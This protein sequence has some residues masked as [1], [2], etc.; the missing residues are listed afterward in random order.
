MC[1]AAL[2]NDECAKAV[3]EVYR[4][5]R[6]ESRLMICRCVVHR[7]VFAVKDKDMLKPVDDDVVADVKK[8][9]AKKIG[10][11]EISLQGHGQL[12]QNIPGIIR[13]VVREF[14]GQEYLVKNDAETKALMPFAETPSHGSDGVRGVRLAEALKDAATEKENDAAG[15]GRGRHMTTMTK[16]VMAD[17]HNQV[18]A[19]NPS[20]ASDEADALKVKGIGGVSSGTYNRHGREK[21][22]SGESET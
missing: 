22:R 14:K 13:E 5:L 4:T 8:H 2:T 11:N 20:R 18:G 7:L 15:D 9:V 17:V 21:R 16:Y 1:P 19:V 3:E 12:T 6:R 10:R